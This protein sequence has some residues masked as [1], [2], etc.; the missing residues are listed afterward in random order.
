M[1]NVKRFEEFR[2]TP[3]Y[4]CQKYESRMISKW[5]A[6]TP[7]NLQSDVLSVYHKA[8]AYSTTVRSSQS[9]I[10]ASLLNNS[11]FKVYSVKN[12]FNIR[13]GET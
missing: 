12:Y 3:K 7:Y 13:K 4:E 1:E 6:T 5:I 11:S 2:L 8:L 9:F 10:E